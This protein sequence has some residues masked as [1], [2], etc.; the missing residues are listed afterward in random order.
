MIAE[1]G[2]LALY[3][4]VVYLVSAVPLVNAQETIQTMISQ[5]FT[6]IF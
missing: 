2:A 1:S 3:G 6:V 4:L 5:V